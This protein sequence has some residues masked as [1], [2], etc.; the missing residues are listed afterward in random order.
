MNWQDSGADCGC[1]I[2]E[3]HW[4]PMCLGFMGM[5]MGFDDRPLRQST[6]RARLLGVIAARM[7]ETGE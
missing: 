7:G 2:R 3:P 6:E 4:H 1:G 5:L